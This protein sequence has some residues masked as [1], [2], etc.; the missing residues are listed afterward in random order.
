M[1]PSCGA[2]ANC[3]LSLSDSADRPNIVRG[4]ARHFQ[5]KANCIA[6]D[7]CSEAG[8]H[9]ECVEF[10]GAKGV[11]EKQLDAA[12]ARV[13][14]LEAVVEE[15]K[16]D[17]VNLVAKINDEE[18]KRV[19]SL[20]DCQT[21]K[22]RS[23]EAELALITMEQERDAAQNELDL[24]GYKLDAALARVKELEADR[25]QAKDLINTAL[26]MNNGR[27]VKGWVHKGLVGRDVDMITVYMRQYM[28]MD[29]VPVTLTIEEEK[30]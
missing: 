10:T 23:H 19:V 6:R 11:V 30:G 14:E 25:E 1:W 7:K 3:Y 5:P 4:C 13:K 28:C 9:D 27:K 16:A 18:K 12:L 21:F 8:K 26:D 24:F 2:E 22:H 15:M 17:R 20:D 29:S